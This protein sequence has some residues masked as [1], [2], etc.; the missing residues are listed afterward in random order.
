M[1]I[2]ELKELDSNFSSL[3]TRA[4]TS[5]EFGSD[6]EEIIVDSIDVSMPDIPSLPSTSSG[7]SFVDIDDDDFDMPML[8]SESRPSS[9]FSG[10]W[11]MA[12]DKVNREI[13][14]MTDITGLMSNDYGPSHSSN[15]ALTIKASETQ[16]ART[17]TLLSYFTQETIVEHAECD[18][19][20]LEELWNSKDLRELEEAR[21]IAFRVAKRRMHDR[22]RQQVRRDKLRGIKI[23][24]G[25][26]PGQ[27][28]KHLVEFNET[29][30][31]GAAK[32]SRPHHEFT[33][34]YRVRCKRKGRKQTNV[35]TDA[36]RV[37]WQS[38][39]LWSQITEAAVR[40]GKP[41]K[42]RSILQQAQW[43]NRGSFHQLTE[44]VIG[45]WID[46]KLRGISQWTD[47]V[48]A[49]AAVG[50][51]PGGQSTRT[52]ILKLPAN[53]EE[54]LNESF[55]RQA[56][57]IRDHGIP[58]E[59]R[60]NT[61]QTQTHYQMGGKHTWSKSGGKQVM[62]MAMDEKCAFTLVPSISASSEVLPMQTIFQG[63]T[64]SF[65]PSKKTRRYDEAM[66]NQFIFEPSLTGIY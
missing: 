46:A 15:P 52:G 29:S 7:S 61:D 33:E 49:R 63:K 57:I 5:L 21:T 51:S 1:P 32:H 42:P 16:S 65:C 13:M 40:A 19:R 12:D 14:V 10:T 26:L 45:R 30:L 20:E 48:L 3:T 47:V 37:N 59:L 24:N 66:V 18:A 23:E 8:K 64:D 54:R 50:N 55:L 39:F 2:N 28:R 44:Q 41:W 34:D 22:A 17:R 62:T 38:P 56:S 9:P 53:Y 60:V 4:D 11:S 25:W 43:M 36:K 35:K 31:L 27:K 6:D 58:A